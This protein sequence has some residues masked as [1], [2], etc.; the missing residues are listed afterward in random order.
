[1]PMYKVEHL[2]GFELSWVTSKTGDT[3]CPLVADG[4]IS[5]T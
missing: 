3:L 1:M 5:L 4:K 2:M